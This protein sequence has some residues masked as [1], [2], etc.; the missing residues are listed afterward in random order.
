MKIIKKP[1]MFLILGLVL[2][3]T[4]ISASAAYAIS[5]VYSFPIAIN[6]IWYSNYATI[7]AS[8]PPA[9]ADAWAEM[10][11]TSNVSAGYMRVTAKLFDASGYQYSQRTATNSVPA[12]STAINTG[13]YTG[14]GEYFSQGR[15][16]GW[17]GTTYTGYDTKPSPHLV[18]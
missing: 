4:I 1:L 17:T 3:L 8:S 13:N 12:T 5:D 2:S 11:T 16:E 7:F 15:T 6:G 9:A 14:S 18:A 10:D